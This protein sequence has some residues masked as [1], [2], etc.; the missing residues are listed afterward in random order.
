MNQDPSPAEDVAVV[1][2]GRN[3]GQRLIRCL[4]SVQSGPI[5]YVDSGSTD[6][7]I[8]AARSRGA[9]IVSLDPTIAFTAGRARNAGF[10]ALLQLKPDVRYVQFVDGDC[11]IAAGWIGAARAHLEQHPEVGVVFGR[12][13]ERYPDKTVYNRLCDIEWQVAPGETRYCGGDILVRTEALREVGGYR[14]DLIA[15]EEPEL[16]IRLRRAG[17]KIVCLDRSM[18]YHDAAMTRFSQWWFRSVRCGYAYACGSHLHGAAPEWHWVA[19]ARRSWVWGAAMPALI[20]AGFLAFGSA[21]LLLS[22]VY[23]AQI[24]RLYLKRR[25]TTPHALLLSVFQVAGKVPEAV[26][27]ARFWRDSIMG[28]APRLIEYK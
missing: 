1:A 12:R 3:E 21:G 6:G 23:P 17:W 22:G 7:S 24:A 2:I 15:G 20:A 11:E 18:T 4:A 27:Q 28:R 9:T 25:G 16:C 10:E 13:H 5:V 19:E 14:G 8:E 26:G